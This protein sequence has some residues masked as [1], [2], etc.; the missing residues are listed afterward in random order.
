M[1][2]FGVPNPGRIA[3]SRWF[4]IPADRAENVFI[5]YKEFS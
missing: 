1:I 3:A 4:D 2:I 5:V